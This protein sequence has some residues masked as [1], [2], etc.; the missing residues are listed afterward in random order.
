MC[1]EQHWCRTSY[2]ITL[3]QGSCWFY[4]KARPQEATEQTG[5]LITEIKKLI[6]VVRGRDVDMNT[7]F[8]DHI[9]IYCQSLFWLF[10]V[11]VSP[12]A[13]QSLIPR[14]WQIEFSCTSLILLLRL[15][16]CGIV[17]RVL[18]VEQ[19]LLHLKYLAILSFYIPHKWTN[20]ILLTLNSP[21]SK[22]TLEQAGGQGHQGFVPLKIHV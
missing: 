13:L 22:F 14:L 4:W 21:C 12:A 11:C 19:I 2:L 6:T 5:I 7:G 17:L 9:A 1:P 16:L 8:S 18:S 10:T 3:P 15:Y 20:H